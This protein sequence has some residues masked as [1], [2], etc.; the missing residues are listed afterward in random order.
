MKTGTSSVM[1]FLVVLILLI[2]LASCVAVAAQSSWTWENYAGSSQWRVDV[3]ED[4]TGCG[5]SSKTSSRAVQIQHNLKI[6]DVG[7]WAH[8][9]ARG[10]F[11]GNTLSMPERTI[12]DAGGTSKLYAFTMEF[13]SDCSGFAGKYKW[14]YRGPQQACS[15]STALRGTRTDGKGCPSAN[16]QKTEVAA[17]EQK[18]EVNKAREGLDRLLLLNKEIQDLDHKIFLL[19]EQEMNAEKSP[20]RAELYADLNRKVDQADVLQ[21][22]VEANYRN[23]LNKDPD[24]FW[25]NWDLAELEKSRG[26][27]KA[28][29][30][31]FDRAVTNERMESVSKQLK[32]KAA[33]DLGLL[34]FP[35]IQGSPMV[36]KLSDD[37]A[38]R[39]GVSMYTVNVDVPKEPSK[40]EKFKMKVWTAIAPD[41]YNTINELVGVPKN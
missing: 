35:T 34:E 11:S 31:Y 20:L 26:N 15:G 30:D 7:D 14:D 36:R 22:K 39:Q 29:F 38:G 10:T 4:E 24:N 8:G 18:T 37:M 19:G 5:G 6:A 41:T 9:N 12:P 40:W 16:E 21:P 2:V 13:T 28:Y 33:E 27:H 1:S 25:A 32:K 17:G 23:I 3:T